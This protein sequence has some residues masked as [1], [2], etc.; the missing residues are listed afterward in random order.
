MADVYNKLASLRPANTNEAELYQVPASTE[1]IGNLMV[2]N[3]SAVSRTYRV[4]LTD[5]SAAATTDEWIRYD[6]PLLANLS[7][8][9]GPI[10]LGAGDTIRVRSGTADAVS[11]VLTGVLI[12]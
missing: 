7:H 11:F 6:V 1:L 4:A 12:T 5:S 8:D 9:I 3:Q 2:C 10:S